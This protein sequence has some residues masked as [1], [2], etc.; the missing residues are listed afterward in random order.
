MSAAIPPPPVEPGSN[1]VEEIKRE[2]V[3]D[4]GHDKF[5]ETLASLNEKQYTGEALV[6]GFCVVG[7]ISC[8]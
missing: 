7:L 8:A 3:D 2:D 5:S 6:A 1:V 4:N